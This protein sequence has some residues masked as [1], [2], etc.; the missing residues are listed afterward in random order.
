ML[1]QHGAEPTIQ[2]TD[3]RNA[4]DLAEPSTKAVLTGEEGQNLTSRAWKDADS[5]TWSYFSPFSGE[6]RKDELLESA[7]YIH[8]NSTL[9]SEA[10]NVNIYWSKTLL[11]A[12]Y[13]L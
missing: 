8:V 11:S 9:L 2:N 13:F 7:R 10:F 6:Y 5:D 1:L 4:L 12:D 3:G